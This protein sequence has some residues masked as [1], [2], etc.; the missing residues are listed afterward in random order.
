[1]LE[2]N[3]NKSDEECI[4]ILNFIFRDSLNLFQK[5]AP[6]GWISSEYFRFLHPTPE[7]QY[8]EHKRI[9]ENINSFFKNENG[10][11]EKD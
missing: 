7:M 8:Q 3:L 4:E 9:T 6:N 2:D 11:E 1:M 10:K 5:L